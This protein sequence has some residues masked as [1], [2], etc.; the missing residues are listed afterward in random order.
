[1][2]GAHVIGKAEF[3]PDSDEEPGSQIAEGFL[4]EFEGVPV[5]IVDADAGKCDDDDSLLF[6]ADFRNT[7]D[8]GGVKRFPS[9]DLDIGGALPVAELLLDGGANVRG[10]DVAVNRK[11]AIVRNDELLVEIE[12]VLAGDGA[13]AFLGAGHIEAITA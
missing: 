1:M 4:Q 8:F 9:F 3:L 13:D 7:N 5:G 12:Q 11:N 6:V 2:L 10:G